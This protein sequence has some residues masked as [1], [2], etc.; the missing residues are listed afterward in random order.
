VQRRLLAECGLEHAE[1]HRS[2]LS[3]LDRANA[4]KQVARP[5]KRLLHGD[6]LVENEADQE[7][8]G[9]R[10]NELTRVLIVR[11]I[12]CGRGLRGCGGN[13][14]SEAIAPR[15]AHAT[16]DAANRRINAAIVS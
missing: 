13:H 3:R 15:G 1:R 5:L 2:K 11:E 10:G 6:L 14:A 4:L 16:C 9:T 8:L 12:Q 7:R